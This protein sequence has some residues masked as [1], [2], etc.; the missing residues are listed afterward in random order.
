MLSVSDVGTSEALFIATHECTSDSHMSN[1]FIEVA[2][3]ILV[4]YLHEVICW[5][6]YLQIED[7]KQWHLIDGAASSCQ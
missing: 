4:E 3:L 7:R 6:E 1:S 2:L 5:Q